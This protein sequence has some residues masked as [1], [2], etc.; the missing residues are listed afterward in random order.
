[1]KEAQQFYY[2]NWLLKLTQKHSVLAETVI[3]S[4]IQVN[5][6]DGDDYGT[7]FIYYQHIQ[8]TMPFVCLSFGASITLVVLQPCGDKSSQI[9]HG[10]HL[11]YRQ[12]TSEIKSDEI[13]RETFGEVKLSRENIYFNVKNRYS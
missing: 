11:C 2:K 4:L 10:S 6:K 1:M 5:H 12:L 3:A 13:N 9:Q 7:H 8:L